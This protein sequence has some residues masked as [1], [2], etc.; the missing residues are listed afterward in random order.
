MFLNIAHVL[1]VY[2]CVSQNVCFIVVPQE[3]KIAETFKSTL[4]NDQ[5]S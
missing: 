2:I 4:K 3:N 5:N 1:T